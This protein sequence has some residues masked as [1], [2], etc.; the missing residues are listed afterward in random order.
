MLTSTAA[1]PRTACNGDARRAVC[2]GN[3]GEYFARAQYPL[4]TVDSRLEDDR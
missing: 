1:V 4:A 3:K 2:Q